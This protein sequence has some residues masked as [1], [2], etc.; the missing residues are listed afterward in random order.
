MDPYRS[1]LC[2]GPYP[3][4]RCHQ[5]LVASLGSTVSPG[6]C[7]GKKKRKLR[8]VKGDNEVLKGAGALSKQEVGKLLSKALKVGSIRPFASPEFSYP[9]S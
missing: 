2:Y 5:P 8:K 4:R 9:F 1:R 3:L 7:G 6:A